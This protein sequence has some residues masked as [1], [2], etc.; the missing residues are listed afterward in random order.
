MNLKL[1]IVTLLGVGLAAYLIFYVGFGAVMSAVLTVGWGGFALLVALALA[2]L[3]LVGA[4]WHVLVEGL[5][6]PRFGGNDG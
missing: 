6:P 4:A 2:V 1:V 3:G 5:A